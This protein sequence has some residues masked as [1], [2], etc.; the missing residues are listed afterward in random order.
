MSNNTKAKFTCSDC[1]TSK[2]KSPKSKAV[3]I[4][5]K[6]G[7]SMEKNIEELIKSVS[8][9][10]SKFDNFSS[11]IDNLV[12]EFKNI[13]IVNEKIIAE[14]KQL[15]DQVS[16]LKFKIDK[17]EQQN[18]GIT[19]EI[20]GIPKSTNENCISIV[21]EIGKKTNTKLKDLEAYRINSFIS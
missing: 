18:L 3:E 5:T 11:K 17:I 15:S 6:P 10:S 9:R 21:E 1:Q 12:S 2:S 7:S 13:K 20:K 4:I 8:F 16:L 19:V 14:N